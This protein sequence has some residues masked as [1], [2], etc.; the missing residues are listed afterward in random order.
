V[1]VQASQSERETDFLISL[2]K[3]YKFIKGVV[4]W[5]NL[6]AADI[7]ER[8]EWYKSLTVVKGFRYSLAH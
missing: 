3:Q 1:V 7:A 8:L 2:A 5:V 6:Q 4:G